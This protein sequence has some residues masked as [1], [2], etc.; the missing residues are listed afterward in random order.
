[1][2]G[3]KSEMF[4]SRKS[5][6]T[7][8]LGESMPF[9]EDIDPEHLSFYED[10]VKFCRD[11]FNR[12]ITFGEE[13][14]IHQKEC[15]RALKPNQL[16]VCIRIHESEENDVTYCDEPGTRKLGFITVPMTDTTVGTKREVEVTVHFGGTEIFVSGKDLT[17][18]ADVQ[19]VFFMNYYYCVIEK[20]VHYLNK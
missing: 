4:K 9:R 15:Y 18:G 1:M 13:I 6:R 14:E 12:L 17:T 16:S 20:I 7:Y 19:A 10:N 3:W 5:K 8:G 11:L 2:F